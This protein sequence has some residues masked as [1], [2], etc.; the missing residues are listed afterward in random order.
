MTAYDLYDVLGEL[1]YGLNPQTCPERADAF[2][3]KHANWLAS[4]P[5]PT[6]ATIEAIAGQFARGGTPGLENPHVFEMA[7]IRAAGGLGALKAIGDAGT[8][9]HKTKERMFA[10]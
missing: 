8:V 1:G 10:A 6:A 4:L 2:K 7:E 3:Y 9:W 5:K